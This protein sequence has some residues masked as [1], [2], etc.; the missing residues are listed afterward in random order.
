[1]QTGA[2]FVTFSLEDSLYAVTVHRVQ[3]ILDMRPIAR[4]P[5]TPPHLLGVIDLRGAT[6][7]VVD[8]RVLLGLPPRQ[9]DP[10]TRILVVHLETEAADGVIGLR[11]D[12]VIDVACLDDDSAQPLSEGQRRAWD[13]ASIHSIGRRNGQVVG[14]IDLD[15]LFRDVPRSGMAPSRDAAA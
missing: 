6:V 1:M 12:R 13:A 2:D 14:I 3:E 15:G 7:P 10:Q 9:D 5:G 11:T 8:M 4:M